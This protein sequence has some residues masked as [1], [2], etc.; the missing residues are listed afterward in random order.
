MTTT[1]PRCGR[2][3]RS[4]ATF[5]AGCGQRLT[6]PAG[7]PTASLA[8]ELKQYA[9]QI[10]LILRQL[11]EQA[12]QEAA[13]WYHD[14]V[15]RQPEVVGEIV[16]TPSPATVTQTV[17]FRALLLPVTS[18]TTQLPA[19][20][21][22]V[23]PHAGGPDQTVL[24]VGHCQ[25]DPLQ[26]GDRVRGWGVWERDLAALRTWRVEVWERG[27]QPASYVAMTPR[28]FP[29]AAMSA[30]LLGFLLL[31]CLCGIFTR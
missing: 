7:R 17:Q 18:Q 29:L 23:R 4:G 22:L 12:R 13:A 6:P 5:C 3:N 19:L 21:F 25:G 24:M 1:C 8:A 14:L 26:L 31:S 10:G 15:T 27:G 11:G 28:P 16:S 20:S 9:H 2:V 30:L